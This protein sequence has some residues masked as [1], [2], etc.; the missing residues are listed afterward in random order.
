M[1]I[2]KEQAFVLIVGL[3]LFAYLLEAIVDPLTVRLATPYAYFSAEYFL[4]YPFT[5]ATVIIRGL[6]LFLAPVFFT[7]VY[8]KRILRQARHSYRSFCSRPALLSPRGCF[9]HNHD[10]S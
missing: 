9:K 10:A 3:F 4:K 8:S 6:S 5:T 1:K 2:P 7:F